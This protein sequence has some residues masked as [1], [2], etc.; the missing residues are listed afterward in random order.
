MMDTTMKRGE[1][2]EYGES[3]RG[4]FTAPPLRVCSLCEKST[5]LCHDEPGKV[6]FHRDFLDTVWEIVYADCPEVVA[7]SPAAGGTLRAFF[8]SKHHARCVSVSRDLEVL[9]RGII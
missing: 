7:K 3:H 6:E 4:A 5:F 8:F 9:C 1:V 2:P